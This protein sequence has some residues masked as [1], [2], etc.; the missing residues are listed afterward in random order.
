MSNI[1]KFWN[2]KPVNERAFN[3]AYQAEL[4]A[5]KFLAGHTEAAPA[6]WS[7]EVR[8]SWS[9]K[10]HNSKVTHRERGTY[11]GLVAAQDIFVSIPHEVMA[12]ESLR[13]ADVFCEALNGKWEDFIHLPQHT[14]N[15]WPET[16]KNP[17]KPYTRVLG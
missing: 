5:E 10:G 8:R 16:I 14:N 11:P 12:A 15:T 13:R 1:N 7:D 4:T 6:S 3:E 9:Q 17:T 2:N